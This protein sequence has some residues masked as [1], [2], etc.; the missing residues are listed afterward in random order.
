MLRP[1]DVALILLAAGRSRRFD[2]DKLTEQLGGKPLAF[3]A[4]DALREVSFAR[5]IAV[6]SAAAPDFA[7]RGYET[8][9]NPDPGLGQASSLRHGIAV[10]GEANCAAALIVLAD[11]PCITA[12]HVLRLIDSAERE[13]AIVASSDGG[14][15]MPP[16]LFGRRHFAELRGLTGDT[17]ARELVSRGR[18]VAAPPE[19]LVDIDTRADLEALRARYS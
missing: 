10:A 18:L 13:D 9:E 11:M 19:E 3:H 15:A 7:A 12:A 6:V 17:G 2:G 4:V 14:R 1:D 16:A 8:V 5:R